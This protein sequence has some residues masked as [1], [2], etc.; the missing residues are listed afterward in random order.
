MLEIVRQV[1]W[2]GAD[3]EKEGVHGGRK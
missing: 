1:S 3:F 2:F